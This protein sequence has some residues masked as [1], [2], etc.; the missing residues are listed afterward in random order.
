M[1]EARDMLP[2]QKVEKGCILS[3]AGDVTVGFKV[4]LP[5]IFSLSDSD[6]GR[7]HAAWVR[8]I[9]VLPQHSVLHKQDW[10]LEDSFRADFSQERSF[11]SAS[12]ERFFNERPFLEHSCYLYLTKKPSGRKLSSSLL[13]NVLRTSIVPR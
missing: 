11:L 5:E 9:R 4:L 2:L 8:A 7:F 10:F 13:S 6:Y 1:V 12:S 3:M